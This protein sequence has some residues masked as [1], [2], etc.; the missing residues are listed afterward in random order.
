[1]ICCRVVLAAPAAAGAAV[2]SLRL[3]SLAPLRLRRACCFCFCCCRRCCLRRGLLLLLLALWSRNASEILPH[4][5]INF[6][7]HIILSSWAHGAELFL[8]LFGGGPAA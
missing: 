7:G 6:P 5:G 3:R 1:M 8:G 4:S 2:L